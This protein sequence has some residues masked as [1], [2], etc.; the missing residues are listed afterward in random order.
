MQ[1]CAQLLSKTY[2]LTV[3]KIFKQNCKLHTRQNVL[4]FQQFFKNPS[5][6]NFV[7]VSLLAVFSIF[8][9][10]TYYFL[11]ISFYCSIDIIFAGKLFKWRLFSLINQIICFAE[12]FISLFIFSFLIL[13]FF[14]LI[15]LQEKNICKLDTLKN[16][17][18]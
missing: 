11:V 4:D 18:T 1:S 6:V 14:C 12:Y 2:K 17:F 7:Y 15:K 5:S 10:C 3:L 8:I 16:K 9:I 13:A